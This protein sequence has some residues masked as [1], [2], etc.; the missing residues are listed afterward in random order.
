MSAISNSLDV[1]ITN[2]KIEN[3][4]NYYT[5]E[6]KF[7]NNCAESLK[8]YILADN[9]KL[10]KLLTES[11]KNTEEWKLLGN[12]KETND[13]PNNTPKTDLISSNEKYK[14]SLKKANGSQVMSG[15][16]NEARA[17][18]LCAC[19]D[20]NFKYD[21]YDKLLSIPWVKLRG[22]QKG[23]NK[24]IISFV[25]LKYSYFTMFQSSIFSY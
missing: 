18:I 11:N 17:T 8:Q 10:H 5:D 4:L 14:I 13:R 23:I 20:A 19:K 16:Y 3:L 24:Y 12:Y 1:N 7:V 15:A 6:L 9:I 2:S 25:F 21:E 22:N